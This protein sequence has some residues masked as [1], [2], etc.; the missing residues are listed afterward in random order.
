MRIIC[1]NDR[2]EKCSATELTAGQNS[3]GRAAKVRRAWAARAATRRRAGGAHFR[4]RHPIPLGN[5]I[6]DTFLNWN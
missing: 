2:I 4:D 6:L 3:A 1:Q 5:P